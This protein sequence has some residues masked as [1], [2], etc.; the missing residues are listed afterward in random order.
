MPVTQNQM[1][2]NSKFDNTNR[3]IVPVTK[4]NSVLDMASILDKKT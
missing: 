4:Y 1:I 3:Y 2:K